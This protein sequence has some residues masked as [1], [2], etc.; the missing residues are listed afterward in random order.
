[1]FAHRQIYVQPRQMPQKNEPP[2]SVYR[3]M[4]SKHGEEDRHTYNVL[5]YMFVFGNEQQISHTTLTEKIVNCNIPLD[6]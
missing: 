1:M 6:G 3:E 4:W 5:F 2:R